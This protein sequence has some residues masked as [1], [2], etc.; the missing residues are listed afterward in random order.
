MIFFYDKH[1]AMDRLKNV[2][3]VGEENPLFL[4]V[5]L[6]LC[7]CNFVERKIIVAV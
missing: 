5:V 6:F 3:A 7:I 4:V 2:F 1:T